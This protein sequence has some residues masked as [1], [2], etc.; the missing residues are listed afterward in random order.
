MLGRGYNQQ[1]KSELLFL[2][3]PRK[4]NFFWV[5]LILKTLTRYGFIYEHD[6]KLF[7]LFIVLGVGGFFP[8]AN[9]YSLLC[10]ELRFLF[11]NFGVYISS[12]INW[13]FTD[14]INVSH[15]INSAVKPTNRFG[16]SPSQFSVYSV[17]DCRGLVKTLV[18]GVKTITWGL[19]TCKAIGTGM[20]GQWHWLCTVIMCT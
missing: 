13:L 17:V 6:F 16:V 14:F 11:L 8:V 4:I 2:R 1:Q 12:S 19:L 20:Y 5:F 3:L 9:I 10:N 15:L 7:Y 18:C